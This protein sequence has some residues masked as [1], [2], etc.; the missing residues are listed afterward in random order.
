[1]PVILRIR[2]FIPYSI[3]MISPWW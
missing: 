3:L 2:G 1:M